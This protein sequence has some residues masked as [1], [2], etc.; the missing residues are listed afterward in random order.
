MSS[1]RSK[2][3][4]GNYEL[5]QW[6]I[7]QQVNYTSLPLYGTPVHTYLPGDGLLSGKVSREQLSNNS[8][9]VESMLRGIGSTN[10]VNPKA[11]LSV[12]LHG[13]KSLSVIDRVPLFIPAPLVVEPNQR[14]LMQ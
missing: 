8:C 14:P 7:G 12:E 3:T 4:S 5:E 11:P 13:L 6:S 2:N 1:T 10:L 9:D